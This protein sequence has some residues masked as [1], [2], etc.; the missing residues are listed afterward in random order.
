MIDPP[1][2]GGT[3]NTEG[4]GRSPGVRTARSAE[5]RDLRPVSSHDLIAY[6]AALIIAA[7]PP[8]GLVVSGQHSP[9]VLVATAT[10]TTGATVA[11]FG[12]WARFRRSNRG[13]A[14]GRQ[15]RGRLRYGT[16]KGL[17]IDVAWGARKRKES[18]KE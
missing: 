8:V 16:G 4:T 2:N 9:T 18:P 17:D 15:R 11:I 3:I 5:R 1:A 10:G 6:L 12:S 13:D 14:S 7:A